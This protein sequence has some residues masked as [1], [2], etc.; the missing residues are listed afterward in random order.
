[1]NIKIKEVKS[2]SGD[3]NYFKRLSAS[4][5]CK[6]A[7]YLHYCIPSPARTILL[8]FSYSFDCPNKTEF[9]S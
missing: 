4:F 5:V 9:I 1:M 3:P 2:Y 8:T 6:Y 7:K